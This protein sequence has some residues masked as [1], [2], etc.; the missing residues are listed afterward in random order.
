[1]VLTVRHRLAGTAEIA[2]M[3]GVSRQRVQQLTARA[4]F[5]EPYDVLA[6][7]RR[8]WQRA[9]VEAW[10]STH[11]RLTGECRPD[12][13]LR[14]AYVTPETL[15]TSEPPRTRS[16]YNPVSGKTATGRRTMTH[17]DPP[18]SRVH[19]LGRLSRTELIAVC[20]ELYGPHE[21]PDHYKAACL[22]CD[23]LI[24]AIRDLETGQP[25]VHAPNISWAA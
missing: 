1:M 25:A 22:D 4:D 5:P 19:E 23:R 3:L 21:G 17:Q 14:S 9:D 18:R 15:R 16:S 2:A 13:S 7:G 11:G 12:N 8:I 20:Q 24:A 6:A 10:A